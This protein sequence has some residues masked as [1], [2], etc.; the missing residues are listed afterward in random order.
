MKNQTR[1]PI[2]GVSL[3]LLGVGLLLDRFGVLQL[4]FENFISAIMIIVG[5][6]L[7]IRAFVTDHRGSIFFGTLLFLFGVFILLADLNII[8][9]HA[10]ISL[11]ASLIIIGISFVMIFVQDMQEWGVLIPGVIL[12]GT[13]TA[14]MFTRLGYIELEQIAVIS[15]IY[16]PVILI[17][18]GGGLLMR[19]KKVFHS[20]GEQADIKTKSV[21]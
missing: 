6:V 2:L 18:I 15:Q 3:I 11:P 7:S 5:A 20:S 4:Q 17:V 1:F 13:G 16:W 12:M 14:F 21:Q 19:G 8:Q 9:H 10:E